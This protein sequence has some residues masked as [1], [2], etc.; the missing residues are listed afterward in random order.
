MNPEQV[1]LLDQLKNLIQIKSQEEDFIPIHL[2]I[3]CEPT[4]I[5]RT[6]KYVV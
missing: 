2:G 3:D 1:A 6:R 4:P 5:L